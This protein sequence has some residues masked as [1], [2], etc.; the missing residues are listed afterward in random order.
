MLRAALTT[1]ALGLL[2]APTAGAVLVYE[3]PPAATSPPRN[4]AIVV[5]RDD[6]SHAHIVAHGHNPLVSPTGRRVGYFVESRKGNDSLRVVPAQGGRSRR[7]LRSADGGNEAVPFVWSPDGTRMIA[8]VDSTTPVLID[9]RTAH[10]TRIPWGLPFFDASF[11]PDGKQVAVSG[12]GADADVVVALNLRTHRRHRIASVAYYSPLWGRGGIALAEEHGGRGDEPSRFDAVLV[13]RPGEHARVLLMNATPV[14]W[15]PGGRRLLVSSPGNAGA[16]AVVVTVA[17]GAPAAF[18]Q[19]FTAVR[20]L[21][22]DSKLVLGEAGG[23]VVATGA[24]GSVDTL[25]K[26]AT[27]PSWTR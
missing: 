7:L 5:A 1:V 12:E 20:G 18:P 2:C 8:A 23:D 16:S 9:A 13:P 10:S 15:A 17:S 3:R 24:D 27:L 11:S 4:G 25:A 22:R 19:A 26:G 21:S 14:A 6:G